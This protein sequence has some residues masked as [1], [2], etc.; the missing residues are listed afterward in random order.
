MVTD[1]C[2]AEQEIGP[3]TNKGGLAM[4]NDSMVGSSR[5]N[6]TPDSANNVLTRDEIAPTSK[7]VDR[8][9]AARTSAGFNSTNFFRPRDAKSCRVGDVPGM[10][11]A[12]NTDRRP[13]GFTTR[14]RYQFNLISGYR[15]L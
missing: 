2:L 10:I 12:L 6:L 9:D 15:L 4:T 11:I 7:V 14:V 8:T 5:F 3:A 13:R 1:N